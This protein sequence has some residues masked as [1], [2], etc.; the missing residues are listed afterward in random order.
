MTKLADEGVGSIL[1]EAPDKAFF[2]LPPSMT[3]K[4]KIEEYVDF[5]QYSNN[6][7]ESV[8]KDISETQKMR[9]E[10]KNP[11]NHDH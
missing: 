8:S 6:F 1:A 7:N 4:G 11:Y 2:K 3:T 10:T 9:L 5:E